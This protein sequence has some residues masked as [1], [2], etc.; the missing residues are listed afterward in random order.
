MKTKVLISKIS[1]SVL[2]YGV[3]VFAVAIILASSAGLG[4]LDAIGQPVRV[5]LGV[6]PTSYGTIIVIP[7]NLIFVAV[8]ILLL[9]LRT[10]TFRL[11]YFMA[12][13][14]VLVFGFILDQVLKIPF[15][16]TMLINGAWWDHPVRIVYAI[17]GFIA[18][19][20]V[21][22]AIS[23]LNVAPSS[24]VMFIAEVSIS[25]KFKFTTTQYIFDIG[26]VLLGFLIL[27]TMSST[28][29]YEW[30]DILKIFGPITLLSLVQG[31]AINYVYGKSVKLS[32]KVWG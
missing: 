32:T 24:Y 3:L 2:L 1:L 26:F 29:G 9:W 20:S 5:L 17:L 27:A 12:V 22:G 21:L 11:D 10:K 7:L 19:V 25:A 28:G 15:I 18:F 14:P 16:H 4:I 31:R 6:S 23:A 30:L 13:I 8:A